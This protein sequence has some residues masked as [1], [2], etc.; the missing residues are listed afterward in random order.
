MALPESLS[1]LAA[2]TEL[3]LSDNQLTW[4]PEWLGGRGARGPGPG[5]RCHVTRGRPRRGRR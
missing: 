2:L 5:F 3:D 1:G 4:L